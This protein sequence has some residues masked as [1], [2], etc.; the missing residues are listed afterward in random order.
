[1]Y[2]MIIISK[3]KQPVFSVIQTRN[4]SPES[5]NEK[6]CRSKFESQSYV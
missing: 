1:M 6:I 3:N 5:T 2:V 4:T